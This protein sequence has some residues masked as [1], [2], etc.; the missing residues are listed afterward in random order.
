M[1]PALP[2]RLIRNSHDIASL[3]RERHISITKIS[4]MFAFMHGND[5]ETTS[6]RWPRGYR[7]EDRLGVIYTP[8]MENQ[9]DKKMDN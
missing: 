6:L 4:I 2:T 5:T 8:E 9:M 3:T 7:G 1:A